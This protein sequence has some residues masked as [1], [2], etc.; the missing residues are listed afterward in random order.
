MLFHMAASPAHISSHVVLSRPHTS[1]S[2]FRRDPQILLI[3]IL[4][5]LMHL[6][7]ADQ[8]TSPLV[9]TVA[10]LLSNCSAHV[11]EIFLCCSA[12]TSLDQKSP[13]ASCHFHFPFPQ[14]VQQKSRI[15]STLLK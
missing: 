11:T 5:S 8:T 10:S 9:C 1:E 4:Y 14:L 7:A 13:V 15:V 2:I 6:V 12:S 3:H